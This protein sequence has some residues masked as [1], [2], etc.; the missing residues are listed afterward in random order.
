MK[1]KCGNNITIASLFRCRKNILGKKKIET[2]MV[3]DVN[4][5]IFKVYIVP[6]YRNLLT[7]KQLHP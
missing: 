4:D 7:D 3:L 5:A 6:S 2:T 1:L